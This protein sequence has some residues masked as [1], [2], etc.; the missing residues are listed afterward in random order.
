ML[1]GQLASKL[2]LCL[3]ILGDVT[4]QD[5]RP[6]STCCLIR[7]QAEVELLEPFKLTKRLDNL[8]LVVEGAWGLCIALLQ[9]GLFRLAVLSKFGH[10]ANWWLRILV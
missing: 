4:R 9:P 10:L 2:F 6:Y 8:Q 5:A 3:H 7:K 1:V